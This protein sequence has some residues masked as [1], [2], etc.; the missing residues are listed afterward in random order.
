MGGC[1]PRLKKTV[2]DTGINPGSQIAM[3]NADLQRESSHA[4]TINLLG[5][6]ALIQP[7][8]IA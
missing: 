6:L 5:L 4:L 2:A 1:L 8:I 7:L 3:G